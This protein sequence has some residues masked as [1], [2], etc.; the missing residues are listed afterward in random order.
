MLNAT[1]TPTGKKAEILV[2]DDEPAN[3]QLLAGILNSYGH[4]VRVAANGEMALRSMCFTPPELVLL[5][6]CLPD[7]DGY[8]VCR[9]IKADPVS[10]HIPVLFVT[11][12]SAVEEKVKAFASGAAD[13]I[14]KPFLIPEIMAR[15]AV[16]LTMS[17][18]QRDLNERQCHQDILLQRQSAQL[19]RVQGAIVFAMA[20]LAEA[21]DPDIQEHLER[22]RSLS[23]LLAQGLH[24]HRGCKDHGSEIFIE[25]LYQTSAL[26][27]VGKSYIP[28]KVLLKSGQLT[29]K[30]M[31]IVRQHT[32]LGAQMLETICGVYP[33]D[34]LKMATDV[35]K[36]HHEKWDG[37]GYPEGLSGENI[38]LAAR[39]MGIVDVYDA[40]RSRRCYKEALPHDVA[41]DLIVAGRGR[42]FDPEL[43]DIFVQLAEKIC[44]IYG[45]SYGIIKPV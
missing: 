37:S 19:S 33:N 8:E 42:D 40:I 24:D 17:R 10:R 31:D 35:A 3:L 39:I 27:D 26:H 38:P 30:E 45:E 36:F 9:R 21:R 20:Q 23:K 41:M 12:L 34:M 22:V 7:L 6:V 43:V 5:D 11:A 2:V 25:Q 1:R 28:D 18:S 29:E 14:T 44:E 4:K 32:T 15:I 13:Y 16:H